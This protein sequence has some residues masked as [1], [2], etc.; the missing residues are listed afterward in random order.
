MNE[1]DAALAELHNTINFLIQ[2]T[3][4]L[5]MQLAAVKASLSVAEKALAEKPDPQP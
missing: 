4:T 5:S 1:T 3:V 2:R